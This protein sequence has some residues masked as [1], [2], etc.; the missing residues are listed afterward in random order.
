MKRLSILLFAV[1]SSLAFNTSSYGQGIQF[2][3]PS[4]LSNAL[5]QA[6]QQN[7]LVF[8]EVYLNGCPHCEAL[9]P[10][11]TDKRVGD[12]FNPKFVS[13]KIE[14]N[15]AESKQIQQQKGL[16]YPEFPLFFFFDRD[17]RLLHQASPIEKPNRAEFVEEVNKHAREA[18][19]P[20]KRSSNYASRFAKGDRDL[21]FLINYGKYTRATKDTTRLMEIGNL[22]ARSMTK[23]ADLES[24]MGF[25]VI[26]RLIVD[27]KNP[28]AQYYFK[29]LANYKS[30]Y[31]ADDIKNA[32]EMVLFST[33][34]GK[35][36]NQLSSAEVVQIRQEMIKLGTPADVAAGRTLLKEL[37]AYFRE[38]N[39]AKATA[40]FD[41]FIKT[42]KV[43]LLDYAY[44]VRLFNERATDNSYANSLIKWSNNALRLVKP[45]EQNSKEVAGLYYEQAQAYKRLNN[46]VEGKRAAE[47]ALAVAKVS[48]E[49]VGRYTALVASFK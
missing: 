26:Q 27:Y 28:I 18:L 41:T 21:M 6:R 39:T 10:V 34:Y 17:G 36:T 32:G 15:S 47:K 49:N 24:Q 43:E 19:D 4:T 46:K 38:K 8:L 1:L 42:N 7:K 33:L 29:N 16:T 13:L 48:G 40:R 11:L 25:Y 3:T 37:E 14:A 2:V 23:P 45:G 30:K 22:L 31:K 9:A 12:V 44:L 20:A 35:R 5:Q